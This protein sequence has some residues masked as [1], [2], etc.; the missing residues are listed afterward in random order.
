M[1]SRHDVPPSRHDVPP[2]EQPRQ[3]KEHTRR[4]E[5]LVTKLGEKSARA[6]TQSHHQASPD[7]YEDPLLDDVRA[8]NLIIQ[9]QEELI[10]QLKQQLR[11][12]RRAPSPPPVRSHAS[13]PQPKH[14]QAP[15]SHKWD[16]RHVVTPQF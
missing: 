8:Q 13:G 10:R 2:L 15:S 14:D 1:P 16:L 12:R 9:E 7:D 4:G 3:S 11:E 5:K 6:K